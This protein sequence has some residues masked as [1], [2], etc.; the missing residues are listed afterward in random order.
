[1]KVLWQEWTGKNA[2]RNS[3]SKNKS[4]LLRTIKEVG[5]MD[6]DDRVVPDGEP[7]EITIEDSSAMAELVTCEGTIFLEYD[8]MD[9]VWNAPENAE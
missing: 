8:E 3:L 5:A 1:M 6:E 4:S 2:H 7:Q 9:I